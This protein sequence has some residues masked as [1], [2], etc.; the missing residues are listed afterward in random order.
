SLLRVIYAY[1]TNSSNNNDIGTTD[2]GQVDVGTVNERQ[3]P[4]S[5]LISLNSITEE[6]IHSVEMSPG[7]DYFFVN[8]AS[9]MFNQGTGLA[10]Y[11]KDSNS[12]LIGA[13]YMEDCY[14]QGH[15]MNIASGS[16]LIMEGASMQFDRCLPIKVQIV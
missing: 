8:L 10:V 15:Q 1:Y 5:R 13:M 7:S 9:D 14:V 4:N 2:P 16:V 11:F 12:N 6:S 3:D